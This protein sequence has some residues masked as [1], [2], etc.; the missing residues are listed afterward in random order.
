MRMKKQTIP[1]H[2]QVWCKIRFWQK[3]NEVSDERL[4]GY[5]MLSA[6]TLR[7]YDADSNNLSLGRLENFMDCTGLTLEQLVNF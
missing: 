5:L 2:R 3:L 1:L 4:A 6:R 7:E